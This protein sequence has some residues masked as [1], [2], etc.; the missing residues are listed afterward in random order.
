MALERAEGVLRKIA[1]TAAKSEKENAPAGAPAPENA[2]REKQISEKS[3][4]R[5]EVPQKIVEA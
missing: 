1:E 3:A 4:P 5:D 2:G